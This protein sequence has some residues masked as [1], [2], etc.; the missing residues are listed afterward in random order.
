MEVI[1]SKKKKR[2]YYKSRRNHM[3]MQKSVLFVKKKL[4]TCE[5]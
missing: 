5:G 1:S 2:S 3:N 4:Q